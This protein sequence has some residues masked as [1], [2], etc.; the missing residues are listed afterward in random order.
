MKVKLLREARVRHYVG[1]I[2]EV[3]PAEAAFLFSIGS[4]E[5][6]KEKAKAKEPEAEEVKEAKPK[7]GK[8]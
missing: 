5:E 3:S 2:V 6:V 4:A 8:K 7:K 1:E